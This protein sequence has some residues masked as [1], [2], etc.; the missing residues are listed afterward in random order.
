MGTVSNKIIG[1]SL[2]RSIQTTPIIINC[3]KLHV[4]NCCKLHVI[5]VNAFKFYEVMHLGLGSCKITSSS[6]VR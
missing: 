6:S 5:A 4:I 1:D 3:C 2:I